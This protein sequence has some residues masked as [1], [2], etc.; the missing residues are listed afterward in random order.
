M[1]LLVIIICLFS[2][3]LLFGR[4]VSPDPLYVEKPELCIESPLECNLYGYGKNNPIKY[5]DTTGQAAETVF[6]LA[7]VGAGIYAISQWDETSSSWSK[8]ADVGGLVVDSLAAALPFVPGGVGL[9]IKAAR[10]AD[11]GLDAAKAADKTLK[12]GSD[13]ARAGAKTKSVKDISFETKRQA[14]RQAKRDAGIPTSETHQTHVN[15]V[16]TDRLGGKGTDL[17]FKDGKKTIQHHM[18]GHNFP[19]NP[20]PKHFNNHPATKNHYLY[21]K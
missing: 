14:L 2:Q 12:V 16:T 13:V 17:I 7:S 11:A 19:D 10:A 8:A 9:G 1:K 15:N 18:T 21:E 4:F 5:V 3:S 6:D 20:K